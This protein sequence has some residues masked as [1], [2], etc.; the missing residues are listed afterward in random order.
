MVK[1]IENFEAEVINV[2]IYVQARLFTTI[3][4]C[5]NSAF[6]PEIVIFKANFATV[7][8]VK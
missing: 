5:P 6:V 2:S 8:L 4:G 7:K 1:E 3:I